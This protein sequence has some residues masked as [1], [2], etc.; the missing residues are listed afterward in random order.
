MATKWMSWLIAIELDYAAIDLPTFTVSSRDYIRLTKQV[1]GDGKPTC[2]SDTK[3][4]Q[5]PALQDWCHSLTISSRERTA[6]SFL[7][8][9]K[10]FAA[11]V[12]SYLDDMNK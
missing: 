11:A 7:Q 5:I 1:E 9:L 8:K 4:T 12:E 2:F 3:D 10:T 6:R